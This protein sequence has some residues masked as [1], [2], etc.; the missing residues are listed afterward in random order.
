MTDTRPTPNPEPSK[1]ELRSAAMQARICEAA[2]RCLDR[3]GY[4]ET[5]LARIQ[6]EAKVSRGAIM[7]HFADRHEIVTATAIRLLNQSL[8]PIE[9]R[10]ANDRSSSPRELIQEIWHRVVNTSGGRAMLEI[11]VA[12]RTDPALKASLATRLHE[13]DKASLASI[14]ELYSGTGPDPDDAALLWSIARSFVRGLIVHEQFL[15]SPEFTTRM[16]LRF[17]DLLEDH[18]KPLGP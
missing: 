3:F 7:Y 6:D 15:E 18:L 1:Q 11:L 12:C 14:A 10:K 9:T 17:A 8:R 2:V 16:L 4:A 5:T 13:W